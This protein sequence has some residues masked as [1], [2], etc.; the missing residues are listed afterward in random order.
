MYEA[1]NLPEFFKSL[2]SDKKKNGDESD[3]DSED[4]KKTD[5]KKTVT[6]KK[7]TE[8]KRKQKK[9]AT[10]TLNDDDDI[11]VNSSS[12][13][14]TAE[15]SSTPK[16]PKRQKRNH[17]YGCCLLCNRIY[18]MESFV[19]EIKLHYRSKECLVNPGLDY[20]VYNQYCWISGK[21][22]TYLNRILE[23]C[24]E[25]NKRLKESGEL[26]NF[27]E[28]YQEYFDDN[29]EDNE[30]IRIHILEKQ[31]TYKTFSDSLAGQ[32]VPSGIND[33]LTS[34]KLIKRSAKEADSDD[35]TD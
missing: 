2:Y 25:D 32:T 23:K 28:V 20:D 14:A 35:N 31:V 13:D 33:L 21:E 26:K 4:D 15:V 10:T 19:R 7:T 11:Q 30:Q 22:S 3:S 5:K 34:T 9:K 1:M 29:A 17:K 27:L 6:T 18:R 8:K 16:T 12:A 24:Y